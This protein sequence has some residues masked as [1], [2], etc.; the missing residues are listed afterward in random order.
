MELK[1]IREE[2]D[3]IDLNILESLNK[4]ME[5]VLMGRRLKS[6]IKSPLR[7]KEIFERL[8]KNSF[9]LI[10]GGFIEELY[11][12]IIKKSRELQKKNLRL[13]G[14]QGE[15]GAYSEIASM[16]HN[17]KYI[18]I[19]FANFDTLI[20]RL[21]EGIVD[22]GILPVENS[23]TGA[24]PEVN[25]IL[26]N[27]EL[28]IIDEIYLKIEHCFLVI[29]GSDYR[30]IKNIYSHSQALN[31]CRDFLSRNNLKPIIYYDTAG[32][33]KYISK[34][35]KMNCAAIASRRCAD[36]YK[37]DILKDNIENRK[38]TTRFVILSKGKI[39]KGNKCSIL[40]SAPHKT[41]SLSKILKILADSGVNLTRVESV[42]L[43]DSFN[44]FAFFVDFLGNIEDEKIKNSLEKIKEMVSMFRILGYYKKDKKI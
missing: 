39:E 2:I 24:I 26:L 34:H 14:F 3:N 23:I 5:L 44:N 29:P 19:A 15:H 10:E 13:I 30:D 16:K 40:F 18:P 27:T 42:P 35:K 4:R 6:K 41:G 33:A 28:N 20:E 43:H 17:S 21:E 37:L 12:K 8:R 7:E 9:Q 25:K 1:E 38:S 32:A 31:Q 22:Y 11:K 36:L